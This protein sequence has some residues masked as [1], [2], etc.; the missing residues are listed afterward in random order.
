MS[1]TGLVRTGAIVASA[2]AA[3]LYLL[4]ALGFLSV[5]RSIEAGTTD[6]FAFGALLA[7]VFVVIAAALWRFETRAVWGAIAVV[8]VVVLIGYVAVS[9]VREPAFETWGLLIKAC[10]AG[11]LAATAYL[12]V[13]SG[14]RAV[15][16]HPGRGGGR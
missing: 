4:I 2:A 15:P 6:L 11:V 5:G 14:R 1:T 8:Q 3:L 12:I 16:A 7:T 9:G 10:Q 13:H